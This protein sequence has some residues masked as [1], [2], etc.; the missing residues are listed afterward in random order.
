MPNIWQS[1][2][3]IRDV[4]VSNEYCLSICVQN[5]RVLITVKCGV[6]V[7]LLNQKKKY[8]QK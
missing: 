5:L 6:Q 7:D 4:T 3:Q 1:L 2:Q 8:L